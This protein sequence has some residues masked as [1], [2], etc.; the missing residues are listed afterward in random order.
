[1]SVCLTRSATKFT[2][3][4]MTIEEGA[5]GGVVLHVKWLSV[6][7][8]ILFI[9]LILSDV[10]RKLTA[11]RQ[12]ATTQVYKRRDALAFWNWNKHSCERREL[13]GRCVRRAQA[14]IQLLSQECPNAITGGG[15]IEYARPSQKQQCH[16]AA[17]RN[18]L[19]FRLEPFTTSAKLFPHSNVTAF[20]SFSLN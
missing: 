9:K 11:R 15:A 4:A 2:V 10:A 17:D 8:R 6:I 12:Q 3:S 20:P 19:C 1:M 14:G 13:A 7:S 16:A 18:F 5:V